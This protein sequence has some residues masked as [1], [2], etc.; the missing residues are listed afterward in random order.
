[1][2]HDLLQ[3]LADFSKYMT[4]DWQ[5]CVEPNSVGEE[6]G[7]FKGENSGG[8]DERGVRPNADLSMIAA[9]LVKYAEPAGVALPEGVTYEQLRTLARQSLVFAYSTHK[10]NRLKVCAGGRYWGSTSRKDAVWESSL[11]AMSVAYS[12]F[13]QWEELTPE[14]RAYIYQLL[15]AECNYELERDIPTGFKDD[16]KAEENGWEA[17]VLAATLGLF[18]TDSL[19]PRWFERMREFAINSY[20]HPSD[21]FNHTVVDAW[22]N[23]Q[24]VADLYRGANLYPDYTLENHGLFHTS[25]QNVVMQELGEAALALKLF[26]PENGQHR[27]ESRSLMHHNREVM[28]SVLCYLALSDGELAM[29][30]GNDWSLFLYDQITS[31][32]TL[33]CFEQDP[34]ALLLE[35]LAYQQIKRRQLTTPDGSWLLRA[36]VGARRMGVEA[37]RV[38]MTYLMHDV[39]PTRHLVPTAWHEMFGRSYAKSFWPSRNLVCSSSPKRFATFSWSKSLRSYTGYFAP[40]NPK[41]SNIVVPYRAHNTGNYLGWYEVEGRKSDAVPVVEYKPLLRPEGNVSQGKLL[42]NEG[43]LEHSF[44]LMATDVN[45]VIYMDYVRA[46]ED[47]RIMN[48][49]GG[50]LAFSVDEFTSLDRKI[51][52]RDNWANID[53]GIGVVRID[54][55]LQADK[56]RF[57]WGERA[58]NNSVMTAKLYPSYSD[59]PREVK[60]GELVDVRCIVYYSDVDAA[61]TKVLAEKSISLLDR[62]PA[63]WSGVLVADEGCWHLLMVQFENNEQTFVYRRLLKNTKKEI[64]KALKR[65]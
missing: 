23:S 59:E 39:M 40:H 62:M 43:A 5:P 49:K 33:A 25:Y 54:N 37:H 48:E 15:K 19:A 56:K 7:F 65:R 10:A 64:R 58:N 3:M 42:T 8:S 24:T 12:A 34:T 27:W 22:Y 14:Q 63:G 13:F 4:A 20:S 41:L 6:C 18:P 21:A 57:I 45:A 16:T 61:Q 38:M 35:N 17:D 2:K 36:D 51:E 52:Q 55:P 29:P 28:D 26:S 30:N 47:C 32:S 9:F 1:M 44:V 11:W 31:Y 60:A 46:R 53:G 50:L